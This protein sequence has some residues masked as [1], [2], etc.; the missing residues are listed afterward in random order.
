MKPTEKP[1]ETLAIVADA[2][3]RRGVRVARVA[4]V[5]TF[6]GIAA[7]SVEERTL[8]GPVAHVLPFD[9]LGKTP[10]RI[11][12]QLREFLAR[13]AP[14][15]AENPP[16][17]APAGNGQRGPGESWATRWE[18]EHDAEPAAIAG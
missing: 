17:S 7:A 2:R 3:R 12:R 15:P 4:V 5:Q 8:R 1:I 11:A 10:R 9:R 18:R 14:R 13:P 16:V 6:D